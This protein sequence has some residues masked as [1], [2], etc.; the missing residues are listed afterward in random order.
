MTDLQ[1]EQ[2]SGQNTP[3]RHKADAGATDQPCTN[4]DHQRRCRQLL[5]RIIQNGT[6]EDLK[7]LLDGNLDLNKQIDGKTPAFVAY[8]IGDPRKL[9]ILFAHGANPTI[10]YGDRRET[11]RNLAERSG[12]MDM[13]MVTRQA[14]QRW[15]NRPIGR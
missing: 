10:K 11:L 2:F 9:E 13:I 12:D 14:E 8:D 1:F 7:L 6:V 15:M 3:S 5:N 4:S